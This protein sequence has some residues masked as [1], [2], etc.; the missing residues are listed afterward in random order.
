MSLRSLKAGVMVIPTLPTPTIYKLPNDDEC[1]RITQE[2]L[3]V[4]VESCNMEMRVL[5]NQAILR[6]FDRETSD[7][8]YAYNLTLMRPTQACMGMKVPPLD[9]VSHWHDFNTKSD[10]DKLLSVFMDEMHYA[11]YESNDTSINLTRALPMIYGVYENEG[12]LVWRVYDVLR[13]RFV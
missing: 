10:M 3:G 6:I 12:Q 13:K 8:L 11:L 9:M 2:V 1:K 7:H 5:N 4:S